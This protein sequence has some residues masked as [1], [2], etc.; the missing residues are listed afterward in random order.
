MRNVLYRVYGDGV[1]LNHIEFG[2]CWSVMDGRQETDLRF[3]MANTICD[4]LLFT[5]GVP[6]LIAQHPATYTHMSTHTHTRTCIH[7]HIIKLSGSVC[8]C[9][10][11]CTVAFN[12]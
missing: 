8:L 3:H 5:S 2:S 4:G 1:C 12:P 11:D 6:K 7:I 10:W 9:I